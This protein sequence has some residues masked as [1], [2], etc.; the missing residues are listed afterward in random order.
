MR[1]TVKEK[2]DIDLARRKFLLRTTEAVGGVGL[3]AAAIPFITYLLPSVDTEALGAPITV[4]ISPLKPKEQLTVPWRGQPIWVIRRT[5]E[6]IDDLP[7][8]NAKLRDPDSLEDQQPAYAKNIYRAIKPEFF[9]AIGV[10]THLG[11][12]PNYRPDIAG[13]APDWL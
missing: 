2:E 6:M 12:I 4:D 10:C 3:C 1:M 8:L 13:I 11:C 5:E 7:Q 9:V